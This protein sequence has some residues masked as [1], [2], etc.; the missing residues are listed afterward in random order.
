V[1]K[2]TQLYDANEIAKLFGLHRNSVRQWL[3]QGLRSIDGRRPILVHGSHLKAFL[4]QRKE[5]AATKNSLRASFF[6]SDVD[7]AATL[8]QPR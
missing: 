5:A 7:T 4:A 8:G 3:K 6:V 1:V 2:T